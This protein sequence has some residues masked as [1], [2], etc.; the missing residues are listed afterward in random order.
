MKPS[1]LQPSYTS[2]T[3]PLTSLDPDEGGWKEKEKEEVEAGGRRVV[4]VRGVRYRRLSKQ[5]LLENEDTLQEEEGEEEGGEEGSDVVAESSIA[6]LNHS[7]QRRLCEDSG[8]VQD[9][10][11]TG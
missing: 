7:V 1:P 3:I 10:W 8:F 9:N 6:I 11:T 5:V 2:D 4:A